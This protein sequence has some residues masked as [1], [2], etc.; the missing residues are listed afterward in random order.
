MEFAFKKVV[1]PEPSITA[2]GIDTTVTGDHYDKILCDDFVNVDDRLSRAVRENTKERIREIRT[3]VIE[4]GHPT[5]FIGT[6]WHKDDAWT[7][8]PDALK[9]D[10]YQAGMLTDDEIN[11]KRSQ[12]TPALFAANY[13]LELL[14]EGGFLFQEPQYENWNFTLPYVYGHIDAAF[15]GNH[16]NGLTFFVEDK[17]K[18]ILHGFGKTYDG[19]VKDWLDVIEAEYKRLRC[20][21]IYVEENAD[22]GYTADLLKSRDIRVY[23][24]HER[25]VKHNKISTFLYDRWKDIRW[26][27]KTDKEYLLQLCEYEKG[28]EPDDCA[29]S[30]ASLIREK[31][32]KSAVDKITKALY[33]YN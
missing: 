26:C 27:P 29:D 32:R 4:R 1:T 17:N 25:G 8:L 9:F 5:G 30:A 20:K 31:F 33:S 16:T 15:K 22:K 19:H 11:L 6:I 3:N 24:Y 23:E 10:V 7:M 14:P 2:L 28:A 18:H 12:T 21:G 13:L